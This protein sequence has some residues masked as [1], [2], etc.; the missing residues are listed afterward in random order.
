MLGIVT[1]RIGNMPQKMPDQA[2]T[3]LTAPLAS[4][5]LPVPTQIRFWAY[6]AREATFRLPALSLI[7]YR[8]G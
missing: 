3:I 2:E 4:D 7:G 6:Q 8:L 5:L 1:G